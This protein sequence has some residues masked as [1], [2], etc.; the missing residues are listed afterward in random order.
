M[1]VIKQTEVVIPYW[2]F[3]QSIG[4]NIKGQEPEK[5]LGQAKAKG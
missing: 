4:P 2:L 3:G 1:W 5:K